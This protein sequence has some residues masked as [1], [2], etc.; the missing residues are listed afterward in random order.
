M[1]LYSGS[2]IASITVI[3]IRIHLPQL[4]SLGL[5]EK[6]KIMST[7][8]G[9]NLRFWRS[10]LVCSKV[11]TVVEL[12]KNALSENMCVVIG[13]QCTSEADLD[14]E[15]DGLSGMRNLDKIHST[16]ESQLKG[17]MKVQTRIGMLL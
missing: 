8:W 14:K 3:S 5:V 11:P 10:F 12:T 1:N 13:L 6:K 15:L 2:L 4:I 9:S 7:Y 17:V 16:L